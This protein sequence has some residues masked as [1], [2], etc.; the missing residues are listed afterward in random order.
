MCA[1]NGLI[2]MIF[3]FF[4][5]LIAGVVAFFNTWTQI[6]VHQFTLEE[7]KIFG[8]KAQIHG[9]ITLALIL[10][11]QGMLAGALY[12]KKWVYFEMGSEDLDF[13][14]SLFSIDKIFRT[15]NYN[16]ECLSVPYCDDD[17]TDDW[18]CDTFDALF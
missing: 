11:I 10:A 9:F 12:V 13:H 1:E 17:D 15:D 6:S 2:M 14:G 3:A 8:C 4:F 18:V 5:T 7:S 16:W